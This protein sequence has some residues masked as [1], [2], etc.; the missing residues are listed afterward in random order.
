MT[1]N[2]INLLLFSI[3]ASLSLSCSEEREPEQQVEK[4]KERSTKATAANTNKL[5]A[6]SITIATGGASGPY[7]T[8]ATALAKHYAQTFNISSK[9]QT[10]GASVENIN[11]VAQGKLEM[12]FV[13]S[14]A[15]S[16]AIAGENK[17]S[18]PI[19][20]VR[21]V[22]V[23]YPNFVQVVTSEQSAIT[24]LDDLRGKRVGVGARNSGTEVSARTLIHGIGL[25]YDDMEVSYFGYAESAAALKAKEIDVAFLSSGLPNSSILDLQKHI[26]LKIVSIEKEDIVEIA[27]DKIYFHSAPIPANTY[28]N[29][30]PVPTAVISNALIVSSNLSGDDVYKLTKTF[31]EGLGHLQAAHQAAR[32]ITLERGAKG[33]VAPAHPGAMRYYQERGVSFYSLK[34]DPKKK[35]FD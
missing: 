22:A 33:F 30:E 16:D 1:S 34:R 31:Y 17:F 14:D 11:L 23:M 3:L 12:A 5:E 7:N 25:S 28:G 9:T 4:T 29:P 6:H 21:Q 15:L 32:D 2:K 19:N 27:K 20:N 18:K 10:T 35:L 26:D 8:I 24:T 13:M